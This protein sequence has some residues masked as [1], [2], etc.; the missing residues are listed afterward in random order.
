MLTIRIEVCGSLVDAILDTGAPTLI[1]QKL[2]NKLN[3]NNLIICDYHGPAII[4]GCGT[5]TI[6]LAWSHLN[7]RIQKKLIN[8]FPVRVV[9]D[10][11]FDFI[12]GAD[13]MS[14]SGIVPIISQSK[15]YLLEGVDDPHPHIVH[16]ANATYDYKQVRNFSG[17]LHEKYVFS[18]ECNS[19]TTFISDFNLNTLFDDPNNIENLQKIKNK[20]KLVVNS[21]PNPEVFSNKSLKKTKKP[22]NPS[23]IPKKFKKQNKVSCSDF[24]I[25]SLPSRSFTK[26]NTNSI[27]TELGTSTGPNFCLSKVTNPKLTTSLSEGKILTNNLLMFNPDKFSFLDKVKINVE[28]DQSQKFKLTSLINKYNH[29]FSANDFDLG[30]N[31]DKPFKIDTGDKIPIKQR[32]YRVSDAAKEKISK[33]INELLNQNILE[34][35]NSP[36]SSP[37]ILVKNKDGSTRMCVD[38]RKLNNIT[39]KDSYPLPLIDETF[40]KIGK[41]KYFSKFD[42]AKGFYQLALEEKSAEKTA[43]ITH[44]GLFQFRTIPFGL[45]NA[46]VH[47]QRVMDE[48]LSKVENNN[49]LSIF[50][51]DIICYSDTFELHVQH[52]ETLFHCFMQMGLKFKP[53]KCELAMTKIDFLGHTLSNNL[54]SP[55]KAK[56]TEILTIKTPTNKKDI[57]SFLGLVG[58]YNKFIKNFATLAS[59]LYDLTRK[60]KKFEWKLEHQEA[61]DKLKLAVNDDSLICPFR[62]ELRIRL[63]CDA[64]D[65]GVGVVLSQEQLDGGWKPVRFASKKLMNYQK[66]WITIEKEC[67]AVVW[68]VAY[69]R[70]YLESVE[71]EVITDNYALKWLQTSLGQK[72]SISPRL[73][74]WI[75]ELSLYNFIITHRSGKENGLPDALSRNP[76]YEGDNVELP[77][78]SYTMKNVDQISNLYDDQFKDA[79]CKKVKDLINSRLTQKFFIDKDNILKRNTIINKVNRHQIVLPKIQRFQIMKLYHNCGGHYG[80]N[81]TYK[82]ISLHYYWPNMFTDIKNYIH[83][84]DGCQRVKIDRKKSFGFYSI[85]K[86]NYPW[87]RVGLD[88]VGPLP[89][90]KSGHAYILFCCDYLTKFVVSSSTSDMTAET[91]IRFF[92]EKII[93]IFG[94]PRMVISDLGSAFKSNKFR[95]YMNR[96]NIKWTPSSGYHPQTNGLCER[97]NATIMDAMNAILHDNKLKTQFWD[98]NLPEVTHH[99]NCTTHEI[100]GFTPYFLNFFREPLHVKDHN[101]N[102]LETQEPDEKIVIDDEVIKKIKLA[103]TYTGKRIKERQRLESIKYNSKHLFNLY[104]PGDLVMLKLPQHAKF[105]E[106]YTG[107]FVV[108]ERRKGRLAVYLIQTLKP[109]YKR[110][111]VNAKRLKLY[112]HPSLKFFEYCEP[113]TNLINPTRMINENDINKMFKEDQ[114]MEHNISILTDED[115]NF[116]NNDDQKLDEIN[117]TSKNANT[118]IVV[119]YDFGINKK[120]NTIQP[121]LAPKKEIK[122]II[123]MSSSYMNHLDKINLSDKFRDHQMNNN[124]PEESAVEYFS[125]RRSEEKLLQSVY[126]EKE[127]QQVNTSRKIDLLPSSCTSLIPTPAKLKS[128]LNNISQKTLIQDH[129]THQ[130]K[131]KILRRSK[132]IKE[133]LSTKQEQDKR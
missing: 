18:F 49:F 90:S 117:I 23:I 118:N 20:N 47:F 98:L 11:Q 130:N 28:L 63:E 60:N 4:S 67:Y 61:F 39:K 36:W 52:L 85:F 104:I 101:I 77:F 126:K 124:V 106:R 95:G 87:E 131:A 122:S 55:Q 34:K 8:D 19:D 107:P 78:L 59:P 33:H 68:A 41:A 79:F 12:I 7:F 50:I 2:F 81:R 6:P 24:V 99:F 103:W 58:Y 72:N 31:N 27:H 105:T 114:N 66:N 37:V 53:N 73:R 22:N 100:T 70:H 125:E 38:F 32:A 84:C 29:V 17:K 13:L 30:Y 86:T 51:D 3:K 75:M 119:P 15:Y 26:T 21:K 62:P 42:L 96:K 65:E 97:N 43:I 69:F 112:Y 129:N 93:P 111:S 132:R 35:S 14:V 127:N 102:R 74:R 123:D 5:K 82:R 57:L 83:Q 10:L 46:P 115:N 128:T 91:V 116:L 94:A 25:D 76:F 108:L 1:S 48:I 89:K 80:I 44:L 92:E 40:D 133:R 16:H 121:T 110:H 71:F 56:L 113:Q 54:L 88:F 109:P 9:N 120:Q 64:S 45:C